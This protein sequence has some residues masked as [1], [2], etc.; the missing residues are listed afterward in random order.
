MGNYSYGDFDERSQTIL[1]NLS[2]D[3]LFIDAVNKQVQIE[4]N[5]LTIRTAIWWFGL[6]SS[7]GSN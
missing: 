6:I 3:M 7:C 4:S 5:P 2:D 1:T